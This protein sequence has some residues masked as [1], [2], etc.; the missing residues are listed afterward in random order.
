VRERGVPARL[1]SCGLAGLAGLHAAWAAGSAWP[2]PDRASL[3]D[4]VVGAAEVPGPAACLAVSAALGTAAAFAG[5]WP[6]GHPVI[7][8]A[9][10]GG[11][12]S[13]LAV[14]GAL[15]LA[16]RTDLVSPG[17]VS[18]RFRRLDRTIY[19][20]LCLVL[21]G[22]TVWSAVPSQAGRGRGG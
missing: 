13:V 6:P 12:A 15:G 21:A 14:R 9:G 20:P 17:S 7:R 4:A 16:G 2:F 1:A 8:A 18:A 11:T 22:L 19:S 10:V 5:G 3:A